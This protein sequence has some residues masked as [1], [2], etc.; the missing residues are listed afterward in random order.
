MGKYVGAVG[1]EVCGG[2]GWGSIWGQWVVKY[3]GAVG[4]EVCGGMGGEV[5]GGS[6]W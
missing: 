5:C 4:G 6:G 3:M 1:G 2:S